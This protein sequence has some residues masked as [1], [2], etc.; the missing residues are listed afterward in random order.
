M[1]YK[2]YEKKL[3]ASNLNNEDSKHLQNPDML[4]FFEKNFKPSYTELDKYIETLK[5]EIDYF[6][7]EFDYILSTKNS[8]TFL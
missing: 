3:I 7:Q 2:S 8:T 6:E 1:E 5:A 4:A